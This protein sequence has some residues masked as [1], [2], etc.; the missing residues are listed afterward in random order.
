MAPTQTRACGILPRRAEW[1]C[2][3]SSSLA[4]PLTLVSTQFIFPAPHLGTRTR[5]STRASKSLSATAG[6]SDRNASTTLLSP[7]PYLA[8]MNADSIIECVPNFSEGIDRD[9]VARIVQSMQVEHVRLLD[10]SLDA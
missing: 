3:T 2:I 7:L 10:W 6:G 8:P 1:A 4:A 9:V 5:V